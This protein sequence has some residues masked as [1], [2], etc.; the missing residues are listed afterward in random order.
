MADAY[1][2]ALFIMGKDKTIDFISEDKNIGVFIVFSD[3]GIY[4]NKT[5]SFLVK[6]LKITDPVLH[7]N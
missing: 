7:Q 6:D 5:F 2:T 4:Y 3:G 1:A